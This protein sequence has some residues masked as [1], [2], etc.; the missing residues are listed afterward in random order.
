MKIKMLTATKGASNQFGSA[1]KIYEAGETL[2]TQAPWQLN[3][4]KAFL[5]MG[6]ATEVQDHN[7]IDE[8]KAPTKRKVIKKVIDSTEE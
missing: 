1:T 3:L 8:V 2:D 4:A 5:S 6:V 7:P